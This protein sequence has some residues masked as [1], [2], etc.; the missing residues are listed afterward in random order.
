M[1]A[2]R[3]AIFF[4]FVQCQANKD[5]LKTTLLSQEK[6][7]DDSAYDHLKTE[8]TREKIYGV[9]ENIEVG[10]SILQMYEPI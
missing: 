1:E 10:V 6:L 8:V 4:I 7:D 3:V 2:C 5:E 9:P